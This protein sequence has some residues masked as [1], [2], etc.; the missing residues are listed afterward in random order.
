MVCAHSK[1]EVLLTHAL[2]SVF[3]FAHVSHEGRNEGM[4]GWEGMDV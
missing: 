4:R 2:C 3:P 1:A